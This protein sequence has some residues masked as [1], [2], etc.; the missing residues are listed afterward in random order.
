MSKAPSP[1]TG[2]H[3]MTVTAGTLTIVSGVAEMFIG[4][5][6][7]A[8]GAGFAERLGREGLGIVGV[9]FLVLG[10]VALIGGIFATVRKAFWLAMMG[11]IAGAVAPMVSLFW[12]GF[13]A[14]NRRGGFLA[15]MLILTIATIAAIVILAIG[16]REFK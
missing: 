15:L 5:L 1:E 9:P 3:W 16:R 6:F 11:A 10:V 13:A 8:A 4:L 2:S 14:L 7:I 12:F